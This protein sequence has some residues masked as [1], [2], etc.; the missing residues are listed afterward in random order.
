[1]E[2]EKYI[3]DRVLKYKPTTRRGILSFLS[4]VYDPLGFLAPVVLPAKKLPQDLCR[5]KLGWDNLI[6]EL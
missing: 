1:M 6:S 4:S 5:E 3:L 2:S